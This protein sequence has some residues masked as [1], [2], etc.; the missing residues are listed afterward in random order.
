[1]SFHTGFEVAALAMLLPGGGHFSGWLPGLVC[2][3]IDERP[4]E[5]SLRFVGRVIGKSSEIA[6]R[7]A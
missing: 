4:P 2:L 1:M 3:A 7:F 6:G 5:L